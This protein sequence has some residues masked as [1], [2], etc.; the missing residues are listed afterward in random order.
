M[1]EVISL[2]FK[3]F[4]G[5]LSLKST[6]LVL[7]ILVILLG[8]WKF[9]EWAQHRQAASDQVKITAVEKKNTALT[10]QLQSLQTQVATWERQAHKAQVDFN[11]L[12][13]TTIA[14]LQKQLHD[15]N[16]RSEVWKK[17]AQTPKEITRY[18]TVKDDNL[19]VI[20]AGFV[21]LFNLSIEQ[22]GPT[23]DGAGGLSDPAGF[24]DDAATA[25][26]LSE[27]T[28]VLVH[29]N[30]EAVR[31]GRVIVAWQTWYQQTSAH[32]TQVQKAIAA[33][34]PPDAA[35]KAFTLSPPS[36]N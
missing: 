3:T 1:F 24:G 4:F 27:L 32:W 6:L 29:N 18:V 17:K 10:D 30:A 14:N 35:L 12:Q 36:G 25:L 26:K 20:H 33:G 28:G 15:A 2:F 23:A 7:G 13:T 11:T 31:R 9:Y 21:R 19:C 34:T 16:T 22:A 5:K 8:Q